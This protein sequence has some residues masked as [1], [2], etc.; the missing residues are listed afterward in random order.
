MIRFNAR[1]FERYSNEELE[2][3]LREEGNL[4]RLL[5]LGTVEYNKELDEKNCA[6]ELAEQL[7][8]EEF[9][10]QNAVARIYRKDG[11]HF[12][13]KFCVFVLPND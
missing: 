12:A 10:K 8:F 1:V 13:L 3:C 4:I 11:K 5:T 7:K 9:Q 2:R 6:K